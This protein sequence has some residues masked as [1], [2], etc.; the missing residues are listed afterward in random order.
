MRLD[1]GEETGGAE[2]G[3]NVLD[4]WKVVGEGYFEGLVDSIGVTERS[5]GGALKHVADGEGELSLQCSHNRGNR[6]VRRWACVTSTEACE[7]NFVSVKC[8]MK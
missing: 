3:K 6:L 7:I 8:S 2:V 1:T 4:R 5:E